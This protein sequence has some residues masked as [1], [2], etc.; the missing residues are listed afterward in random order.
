MKEETIMKG[1]GS[2]DKHT[3]KIMIIVVIFL[4]FPLLFPPHLPIIPLSPPLH[5]FE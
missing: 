2:L 1:A 5:I 3:V 4:H